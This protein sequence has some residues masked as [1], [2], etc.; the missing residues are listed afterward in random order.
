M[1]N[2]HSVKTRLKNQAMEDGST[3]QDKLTAFAL[4]RTVYRISISK[5]ELTT[6]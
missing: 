3:M 5:Y 4:E 6:V 2:A 1:T